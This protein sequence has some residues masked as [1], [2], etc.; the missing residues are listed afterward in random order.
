MRNVAEEYVR[1]IAQ[2]ATPKAMK[3]REVEEQSHHN[4]ELSEIR[5]CIREGVW[6]NKECAK[7]IPVKEELCAIGKVVAQSLRQQVLGIA[8]EPGT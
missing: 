4:A 6:N 3:T 7:Y 8:H 2:R 5:R 1:F